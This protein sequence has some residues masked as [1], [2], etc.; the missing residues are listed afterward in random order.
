MAQI[1]KDY[2]YNRKSKGIPNNKND[3]NAKESLGNKGKRANNKEKSN[4][5]IEGETKTKSLGSFPMILV[6][7]KSNINDEEYKFNK[8]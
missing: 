7:K 1:I 3:K 4:E 6:I 5:K 2:G 8:I